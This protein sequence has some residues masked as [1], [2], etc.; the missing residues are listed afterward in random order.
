MWDFSI[1]ADGRGAFSL[2]QDGLGTLF[3]R[4]RFPRSTF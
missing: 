1:D 3:A 2:E 4:T